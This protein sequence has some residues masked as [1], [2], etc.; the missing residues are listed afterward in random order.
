MKLRSYFFIAV[1]TKEHLELCKRYA[2]AGFTN[3]INGAWAYC[4]V[5]KGDFIS[6]LYGASAHNLYE[7][8]E[9]EAISDAESLPPWKPVIFGKRVYHFPF[10]LYLKPIRE[11]KESIARNEFAYIAENLLLR[12]GYRK[13]HFQADQT[14][15]SKVS[16]MGELYQGEPKRLRM[17]PHKTFIPFFVKGRGAPPQVY[18]LRE[19]ILQALIRKHLSEPSRLR[20]F[21][22]AINVQGLNAWELE[23]LGE[24]ALP[25]G[26]VDL[27][28]KEARPTGISR[29]IVVEVKT[30]KATKRDVKQVRSYAKELG[31]E[32]MAAVLIAEKTPRA[33]ED[34]RFVRYGFEGVNLEKPHSFQKL[35][36]TL[37]LSFG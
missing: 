8:L 7:V 36:S 15:L 28:I 29:K 24:K 22:D 31:E 2:M 27:L 5:D 32:C 30:G 19:V 11:F 10:R 1:S 17:P 16:E 12:G 4:E 25:E 3:S 21:L 33:L 35:L 23:V 13:T 20:E 18:P 9:K 34:I 6:F 26:H 14:T 37:Q